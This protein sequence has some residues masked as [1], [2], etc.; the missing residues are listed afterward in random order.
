[1]TVEVGQKALEFYTSGH[2]AFARDGHA[3]AAAFARGA[4]AVL[5]PPGKGVH[6]LTFSLSGFT[7]AHA[8]IVKACPAR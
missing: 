5:H 3:A 2:D 7:A 8:A 1:M 6:P 4:S